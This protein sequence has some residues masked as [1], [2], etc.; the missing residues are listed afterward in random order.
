[1]TT[2]FMQYKDDYNYFATTVLIEWIWAIIYPVTNVLLIVT[3][4]HL[5]PPMYAWLEKAPLGKNY[6]DN[7]TPWADPYQKPT[8]G[9]GGNTFNKNKGQVTTIAVQNVRK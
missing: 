1:M 6:I 9:T 4:Y 8:S 5:S 2:W 3:H 7:A